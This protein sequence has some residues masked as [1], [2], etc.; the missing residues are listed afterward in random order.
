[1]SYELMIKKYSENPDGS[2]EIEEIVNL[3]KF[4]NSLDI[5]VHLI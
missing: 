1:M 5:I 2:F 3:M 4:F